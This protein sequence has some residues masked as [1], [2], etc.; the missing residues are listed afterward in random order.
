MVVSVRSDP[1]NK[2]SRL[3]LIG[4]RV[5]T[6]LMVEWLHAMT[7]SFIGI[8][9]LIDSLSFENIYWLFMC[10]LLVFVLVKS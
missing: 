2:D 8:G 1:T 5:Y 9:Y 3:D 7:L 10:S 4:V 6:R